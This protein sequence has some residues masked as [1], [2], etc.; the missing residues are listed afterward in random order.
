MADTLE[1]NSL[2]V[3][4]AI[5]TQYVLEATSRSERAAALVVRDDSIETS[6]FQLH[7]LL[8]QG[9]LRL[10]IDEDVW[11]A[12]ELG[13]NYRLVQLQPPWLPVKEGQAA[14]DNRAL[15]RELAPPVVA[16]CLANVGN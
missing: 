7:E 14:E 6:V 12:G 13:F 2:K 4:A 5:L 3:L 9:R 16:R 10:D 1:E 11:I 8:L 15:F